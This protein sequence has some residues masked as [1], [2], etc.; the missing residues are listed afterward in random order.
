MVSEYDLIQEEFK[1]EA[2]CSSEYIGNAAVVDCTEEDN[3]YKLTGC[4][5]KIYCKKPS[6]SGYD[7]KETSL[8][9]QNFKATATCS[10]G[11]HGV[12]QVAKCSETISEYSLSGCSVNVCKAPPSTIG[13]S[14]SEMELRQPNFQV[15]VA[16]ATGYGGTATVTACT[17]HQS[18]YQLSGCQRVEAFCL[19][20]SVTEGYVVKETDLRM[21]VFKATATCAPGWS[22]T[23]KVSVCTGATPQVAKE[24]GLSGCTPN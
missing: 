4:D 21:D 15:K 18:E 17:G 6:I 1:V 16:C 12:P 5:K 13:Y 22:G 23:A 3:H 11:Y 14:V 9:M 8:V 20:P 2:A 24:Y 19:S 10:S 7:V